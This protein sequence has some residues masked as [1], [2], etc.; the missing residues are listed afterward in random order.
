MSALNH[1]GQNCLEWDYE[2][3]SGFYP[4]GI[5]GDMPT[6]DLRRRNYAT[7]RSYATGCWA[8][9]LD[10]LQQ[11]G[12]RYF[13]VIPQAAGDWRVVA[14]ADE[15]IGRASDWRPVKDGK[16]RL[17]ERMVPQMRPVQLRNDRGWSLAEQQV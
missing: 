12:A 10:L 3:D 5:V 4:C 2:G 1:N 14:G 17:D 13:L 11:G 15:Y 9:V 6:V 7:S 8:C 16:Y